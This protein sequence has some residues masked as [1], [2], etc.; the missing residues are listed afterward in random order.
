MVK[1]IKEKESATLSVVSSTS[2][3]IVLS[4]TDTLDNVIY[5]QP[6][7][8]RSEVPSSWGSFVRVQQGSNISTVPSV[9]EGSVTVAYYNVVPDRGLITL[10]SGSTGVSPPPTISSLSPASATAGGPAFTLTVNG[11]N[12]VSGSV[13]QWNGSNRTTTFVS[14]TQLTAAITAADIATAGHGLGD[15]L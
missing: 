14:A 11:S 1:Y 7:T 15:R 2:S 5:D 13:V 12:F 8:I 10:T 9:V 6:L 4:L 3:Q